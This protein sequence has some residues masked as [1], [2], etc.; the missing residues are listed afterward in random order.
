M[1]SNLLATADAR[2]WSVTGQAVKCGNYAAT[3]FAIIFMCWK[4]NQNA[5]SE[6]EFLYR[7]EES[8]VCYPGNEV[9]RW[10]KHQGKGNSI[11]VMLSRDWL[12][13]NFLGFAICFVAPLPVKY[14]S[15]HSL[16]ASCELHLKTKFGQIQKCYIPNLSIGRSD[17]VT[18]E[19]EDMIQAG[20]S[21]DHVFIMICEEVNIQIQLHESYDEIEASFNSRY[22]AEYWSHN[23]NEK[24][25]LGST[26]KMMG[27]RL[28][29][30]KE[31]QS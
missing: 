20:V 27:L 5:L 29:Y 31:M 4:L 24:L 30:G 26:V 8:K 1:V 12:N 18:D 3:R 23:K 7:F 10:F 21:S 22:L 2:W 9:P 19:E 16:Q 25:N 15:Y 17:F 28:L 14:F 11:A 13:N 6:P